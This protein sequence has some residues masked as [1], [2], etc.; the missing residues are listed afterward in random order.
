MSR[1]AFLIGSCIYISMSR[2]SGLFGSWAIILQLN[3][4]LNATCNRLLV[5]LIGYK[6]VDLNCNYT[7]SGINTL[8]HILLLLFTKITLIN[9]FIIIIIIIAMPETFS[10]L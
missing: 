4:P 10:T 8:N 3:Q 7:L 1:L 2:I 6:W 9:I 5:Y